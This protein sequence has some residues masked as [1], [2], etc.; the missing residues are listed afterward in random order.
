MTNAVLCN[1]CGRVISPL[2]Q[3]SD[4]TRMHIY[5][6]ERRNDGTR[7]R[8]NKKVHLCSK[9][10]R[11]LETFLEHQPSDT[12]FWMYLCDDVSIKAKQV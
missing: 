8:H 7:V 11:E 6:Y 2:E 1:R 4:F 5:Q 3:D 9:C 10:G 12:T